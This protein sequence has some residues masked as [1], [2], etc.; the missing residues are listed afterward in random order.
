M[1]VKKDSHGFPVEAKFSF[2]SIFKLWGKMS[3]D[4]ADK[5]GSSI[6]FGIKFFLVS[7]GLAALLW[8]VLPNG[9]YDPTLP[10][11]Q[12]I[13]SPANIHKDHET[14]QIERNG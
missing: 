9:A 2:S 7:L 8:V 13:Y 14:H 11:A 12:Q 5:A 1:N 4:G 3:K 10:T 6:A